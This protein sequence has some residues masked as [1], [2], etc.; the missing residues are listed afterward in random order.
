[1]QIA[2]SGAGGASPHERDISRPS[3][4]NTSGG[5]RDYRTRYLLA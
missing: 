3:G 1:L 4:V 2:A 5:D